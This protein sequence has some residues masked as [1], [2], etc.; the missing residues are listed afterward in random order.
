MICTTHYDNMI[1]SGIKKRTQQVNKQLNQGWCEKWMKYIT[2]HP[3]HPWNWSGISQNKNL[4][5]NYVE[6]HPEL[7]WDWYWISRNPSLTMDFVE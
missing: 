3:E 5:I 1:S 4:T 7:P 6:R 2:Q